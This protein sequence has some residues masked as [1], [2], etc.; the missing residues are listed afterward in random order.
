METN[1]KMPTLPYLQGALFTRAIK[2]PSWWEGV[3]NCR[4][5]ARDHLG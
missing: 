1:M 2:R 5:Y 4:Y 3:Y